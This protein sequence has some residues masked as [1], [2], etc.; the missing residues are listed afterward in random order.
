[1][2]ASSLRGRLLVASPALTD[3]NFDRTVVLVVEHTEEGGRLL[4]PIRVPG[5]LHCLGQRMA[6]RVRK[7]AVG[8]EPVER[9]A[10]REGAAAGLL[11]EE[12][13][14]LAVQT[15]RAEAPRV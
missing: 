14:E 9:A 15:L 11:E 10:H 6:D 7:G 13:Q 8:E 4:G 2:I 3:G 1:M 12:R 5:E